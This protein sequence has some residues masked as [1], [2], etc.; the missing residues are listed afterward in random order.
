MMYVD[1]LG[2]REIPEAGWYLQA[3]GRTGN[4]NSAY[5]VLTA[6]EVRR[7]DPRA[8]RRIQMDVEDVD[9]IPPGAKVFEFRWYP[10]KKKR[11]GFEEQLARGIKRREAL[12]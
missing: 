12:E 1:I 2:G 5:L 3:I 8:A 11:R 9:Q 6:R 7:R 10:R 4:K